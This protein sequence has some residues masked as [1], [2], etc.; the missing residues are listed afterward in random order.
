MT[1]ADSTAET[2]AYMPDT[3]ALDALLIN[4]REIQDTRTAHKQI[5]FV[6]Y[7]KRAD[8]LELTPTLRALLSESG[9]HIFRLAFEVEPE[10]I[11]NFIFAV[12][13]TRHTPNPADLCAWED[14]QNAVLCVH[15]CYELRDEFPLV[16]DSIAFVRLQQTMQRI[17]GLRVFLHPS[18][19]FERSIAHYPE[20]LRVFNDGDFRGVFRSLPG[21]HFDMKMHAVLDRW[22]QG[23]FACAEP[24]GC[25]PRNEG[26]ACFRTI[27]N[28]FWYHSY[29]YEVL[30]EDA[31]A[32]FGECNV[33]RTIKAL[34]AKPGAHQPG[35]IALLRILQGVYQNNYKRP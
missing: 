3:D 13:I 25:S 12:L 10:L 20:L 31:S 21:S 17:L 11:R 8:T 23:P 6:E 5:T 18:T 35:Q 22:Q 16:E 33:A 29:V 28:V 30:G 1:A 24:A 15:V 19:L 14:M 32:G 4:D 27:A 34:I 9:E 2:R 26:T 7:A